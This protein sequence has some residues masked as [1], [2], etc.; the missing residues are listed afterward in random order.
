MPQPKFDG[1][2]NIQVNEDAANAFDH[3]SKLNIG[4]SAV[5]VTA[6]DLPAKR[7]V[8]VKASPGNT[9]NIVYL[10]NSDVTVLGGAVTTDG[11]AIVG[12]DTVFIPID[13]V[14]KLYA[15]G[16]TTGLHIMFI[17]I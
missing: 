13:N 8:W 10:G 1:E 17:V 6:L 4:A 15:I 16:S 14:N 5:Q 7:G 2:G 9:T 3:G 12:N 11:Y